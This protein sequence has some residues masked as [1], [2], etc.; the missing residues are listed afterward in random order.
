M[1]Q[2]AKTELLSS[3]PIP[4][5]LLAMGIPTMIG[6]LVN[7]LYNLADA[8]FVSGLGESQ[9]GAIAVVYPLG[10]LV[11]GLGLLFGNGASSYISRQLGR[12]DLDQANRAAGTALYSSLAVGAAAVAAALLFLTPLLRLLGATDSL[13]LYARAYA[14]I[15]ILS[16]LFGVFNVAMNNI[17]TSEGAAKTTMLVLLTGAALNVALDPLL[18]YGLGWGIAGAAA[19]T[20][21]AQMISTCIY[22]WY[23]ASGRS[24]FRLRPQDC[25]FSREIL[26]EILKIGVPTLAFQLLTILSIALTNH[27][28]GRYGD[29]AI[30][31]LGV[32]TRLM[33]VGSLTVFGFLKG[34]QPLAGYSY[35]AGRPARLREA[36]KTAAIWSTAFCMLFGGGCA[37]FAPGI[38]S[39]FAG[40]SAGM[41]AVGVKALRLNCAAF[42]LF[43]FYTVYSFLFLALGKGREG[44]FLGA[45]RQGICLL[46]LLLLLPPVWGVDGLLYAQPIADLL[47]A[48]I[49][50]CM[51]VRLHHGLK[52]IRSGS[53][54]R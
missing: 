44:F 49:A 41:L 20:A 16:C 40:E 28:A 21:L 42:I 29:A 17:V 22:L 7:A 5:A 9:V 8:W 23:A 3:A 51:A 30:A 10:Q 6:M 1:K 37:L 54:L 18:I 31:G 52:Q 32:V 48:A 2:N 35:G 11:V 34:F 4:K 50:G 47:S 43:G 24:L 33:S 13:L 46:P 25:C 26:S 53:P 36:I 27:T 14:G 12:G 15:Y 19:A 38:V 39:R 45:C